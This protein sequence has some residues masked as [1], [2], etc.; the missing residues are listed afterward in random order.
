MESPTTVIQFNSF[1]LFFNFTIVQKSN[2][3]P[4][5]TILWILSLD[6]GLCGRML[7]HGAGEHQCVAVPHKVMR[8]CTPHPPACV[9][10][11]PEVLYCRA[12]K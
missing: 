5:Q 1:V 3:H 11:S 4:V 8:R 10:L 12:V 2:P 7:P 6:L 9:L